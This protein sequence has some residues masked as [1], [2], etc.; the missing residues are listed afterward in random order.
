[1]P[2]LITAP[3]APDAELDELDDELDELDE[4]EDE[5]PQAA[6]IAP[7]GDADHRGPADEVPPGQP[8]RGE[9]VDDVVRYL[10]LVLAQAPEPA[11]VNI[12]FHDVPPWD[13]ADSFRWMVRSSD[14]GI[15]QRIR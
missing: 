12:A 6:R 1:M 11:V 2:A 7:S 15:W 9:F 13:G 8:P 4:L 10:T 14:S 3:G 5:L